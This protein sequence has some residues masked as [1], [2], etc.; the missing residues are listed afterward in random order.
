MHHKASPEIFRRAKE[1]REQ[2]TAAEAHLW[3]SLRA[4]KLNGLHFRRQHPIAN[5]ILDFYCHQYQLGIEIDGE[6]HFQ[7]DQKERDLG[8]EAEL[9][10][11]GLRILRFPN[12]LVL[13][14]TYEV[15]KI[16]LGEIEEI[17]SNDQKE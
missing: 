8:R 17:K 16:I 6:V 3:E 9:R 13:N 4:G 14:E 11:L 10:T 5:F 7:K 2:M 15:L 12:K 1:L